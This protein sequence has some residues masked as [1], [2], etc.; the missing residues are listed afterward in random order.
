MSQQ[1]GPLSGSLIA[2]GLALLEPISKDM[3]KKDIVDSV[4]CLHQ[5]H[6]LKKV[7]KSMTYTQ[8]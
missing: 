6:M 2:A 1:P 7:K 3:T 5:A 8:M 4:R